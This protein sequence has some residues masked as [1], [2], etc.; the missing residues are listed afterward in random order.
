MLGNSGNTQGPH[1]HF[2]IQERPNF[3]SRSVPFV[4][5]RFRLE[6]T[7]ER[8]PTP[9]RVRVTGP[10]R[11]ERRSFPLIRSVATFTP[12]TPRTTGP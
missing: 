5:D 11:M 6:G 7:G 4:I 12:R 2:G 10:P 9:P 1:L 3:F 8:A